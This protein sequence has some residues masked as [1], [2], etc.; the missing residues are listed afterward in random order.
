MAD[1][2]S[3]PIISAMNSSLAARATRADARVHHGMERKLSVGRAL[4]AKPRLSIL[5]SQRRVA[6]QPTI[7]AAAGADSSNSGEQKQNIDG[8]K[9][10]DWKRKAALAISLPLP[11]LGFFSGGNGGSGGSGDGGDGG[12][13]GNGWGPAIQDVAAAVSEDVEE[14]LDEEELDEDMDDAEDGADSARA[15]RFACERERER[16]R[17]RESQCTLLW[18]AGWQLACFIA[19]MQLQPL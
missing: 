16:E 3:N 10:L 12:G 14:D 2:P 7:L 19:A 1:L 5:R 11:I 4:P 6:G 13:D 15:V 17:E 9:S 8:L 18:A